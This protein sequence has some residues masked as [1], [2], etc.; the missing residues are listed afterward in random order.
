MHFGEAVV[1]HGDV[2][3]QRLLRL[4]GRGELHD[5]RVGLRV[6]LW[7]NRS[8]H[9]HRHRVDIA[10]ALEVAAERHDLEVTL[11]AMSHVHVLLRDEHHLDAVLHALVLYVSHACPVPTTCVLALVHQL[12]QARLVYASRKEHTPTPRA[13][14]QLTTLHARHQ[15]LNDQ[16]E[17]LL[18]HGRSRRIV[19]AVVAVVVAVYTSHD[20]F[21]LHSAYSLGCSTKREL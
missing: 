20:T 15:L 2:R 10:E 6:Q 21:T 4:F 8:T 18:V 9:T 14:R 12:R 17:R 5:R 3:L 16:L 1:Q 19:F 11:C 7:V 13:V